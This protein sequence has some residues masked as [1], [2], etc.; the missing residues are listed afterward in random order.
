MTHVKL[1]YQKN[2]TLY[3]AHTHMILIV[4]MRNLQM[5]KNNEL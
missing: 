2:L 5:V 1:P 3:N 4:A